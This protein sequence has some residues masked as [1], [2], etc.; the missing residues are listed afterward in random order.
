MVNQLYEADADVSFVAH[1]D[2]T[3][4]GLMLI[5]R[6]ALRMIPA[7]GYMDMKEQALPMIARRFKVTH[8]DHNRAAGLPVRT[9]QDYL[10][11]VR[12]RHIAR[13][14]DGHRDR[15]HFPAGSRKHSERTSGFAIVENGAVVD[16]TA[17]LHDCV[18]L[19]GARVGPGA[20]VVRS[21]VCAG[22][23]LGE[24]EIAVD[25]LLSAALPRPQRPASLLQ[26]S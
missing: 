15:D 10:A 1:R 22:S 14:R 6:A 19:R 23:V 25:Q 12:W 5:R 17:C 26:P 20:V 7:K 3:P 8:I 2:G 18:I 24:N 13:L 9:F 4:S 16:P 21:V 11:G